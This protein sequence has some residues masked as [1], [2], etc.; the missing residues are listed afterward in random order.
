MR[1]LPVLLLLGACRHMSAGVGPNQLA[2]AILNAPEVA[3]RFSRSELRSLGCRR[4]EEEPTEFLCRFQAR[5][6]TGA[7]RKRTAIVAADADRWVLLS[8]D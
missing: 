6:A 5:E 2:A 1:M 7:W 8:L 4:F 3:G